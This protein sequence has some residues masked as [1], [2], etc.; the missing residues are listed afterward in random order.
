MTTKTSTTASKTKR[1]TK[2][3]QK[4]TTVKVSN[5]V[6]SESI[7]KVSTEIYPKTVQ[8]TS[9]EQGKSFFWEEYSS[10]CAAITAENFETVHY[11]AFPDE[12]SGITF[13]NA[14]H[15][16][17]CKD[18]IMRPSKRFDS[19]AYPFEVKVWG[20]S[21]K[22]FLGLVKRDLDRLEKAN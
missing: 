4:K 13:M 9:D 11:L 1:T 15:E 19:T 21:E 10:R 14:I 8:L 22:A 18:A 16:K 2:A 17:H 12:E 20:M 5:P 7:E 3:T 6:P